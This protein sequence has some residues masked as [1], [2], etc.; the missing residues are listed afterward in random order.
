MSTASPET[1]ADVSEVA[2]QRAASASDPYFEI[3][4]RRSC[5]SYSGERQPLLTTNSTPSSAASAAAWRR[6]P[7]R[8]GS[9]LATPGIP[10]SK[11]VAP[12]GTAPSA[13]PSEP[14]CSDLP[15]GPGIDESHGSEALR[16]ASIGE[17]AVGDEDA[18]D[19]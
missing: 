7:S 19:W 1:W 10:S 11:T 4:S 3:A 15:G 6:A 18:S 8:A 17:A 9:R 16:R 2:T 14:R 13:S 5:S 12:S